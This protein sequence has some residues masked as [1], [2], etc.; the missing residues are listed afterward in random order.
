MI[1]RNPRKLFSVLEFV[2]A[3][4]RAVV[5]HNYYVRNGYV[6]R[7]TPL[8]R[9]A[10]DVSDLRMK[11]HDTSGLLPGHLEAIARFAPARLKRLACSERQSE[12]RPLPRVAAGGRGGRCCPGRGCFPPDPA[13]VGLDE[14]LDDVETQRYRRRRARPRERGSH[15]RRGAESP[16]RRCRCP[17]RR[18]L[19]RPPGDIAQPAPSPTYP[20]PNTSGHSRSG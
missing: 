2:L 6:A 18:P 5:T 8:V 13:V 4:G 1:T 20:R 10:H 14:Q 12:L 15:V 11:F 9:P 7:R 16:P 3:S 19:E 17:R